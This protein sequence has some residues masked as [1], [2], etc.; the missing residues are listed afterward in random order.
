MGSI[1]TG[2]GLISGIDTA[3][4]IDSLIT[5]ESQGKFNLQ[6][7]IATLQAQ[8]TAML[9]VN[10]RLLNFRGA[11]DSFRANSIF[12][13]ALA[14]SSNEDVMTAVA[15]NGTAPGS[16]SFIVN[17]LV[18][19]SQKLSRGFA[20]RDA[21]P[22]GLSSMSFEFGQGHLAPTTALEVL[23]GGSGVSRGRISITDRT[24]ASA[25]VDLTDVTSLAEVIDRINSTTGIDVAARAEGDGLVITDNTAGGGTLSVANVGGFTTATE[26]G[27]NTD[28]GGAGDADALANG[29]IVGAGINTIGGNTPL[30]ALNDGNGVLIIDNVDDL[31]V[32]SK[33]GMDI[34]V[35]LG[36][37]NSPIDDDTL[38]ADL[39]NGAGIT[40]NSDPDEPDILISAKSNDPAFDYEID[41]TGVTTVGEL[42]G[43][44]ETA[45]AGIVTMTV[46]DGKRFVLEDHTGGGGVFQVMGAGTNDTDTAEDLGILEEAGV[47]TTTITG[48][49]IDNLA[50]KDRAQTVQDVLDRINDH[51]DNLDA[52]LA[53]GRRVTASIA[54][55]GVSLMITDNTGGGAG[56][57]IREAATNTQ[58][59]H[60][61][62]LFVSSTTGTV[63]DGDRV[64]AALDSVMVANLNGGTG[65]NVIGTVPL[66]GAT[67]L[68]DLFGGAGL[69]T[70]GNAASPDISITDRDGFTYQIE[71]DGLTT[72]Q[73]LINAVSTATGG[74]VTLAINGQALEI[75]NFSTGGGDFIV[76]DLNGSGT[77]VAL[78]INGTLTNPQG[79]IIVG[80]DTQP[81][82]PVNGTS[83][84]LTDR[85]GNTV[86]VGGLDTFVSLSDLIAEINT[87]AI[88]AGV[89]ITAGLNATGNGV[90]F[91]DTSGGSGNLI[92]TGDAA[93]ALRADTGAAGVADT[94][95]SGSNLQLGYVSDST[96]LKD[97]NYGRGIGT[98]GLRIT[99]GFG[100]DVEINIGADAVTV[101]DVLTEINALASANGV[102]VQARINDHGDGII[103][104][105]TYDPADTPFLPIRVEAAGGTTARDLN[106]LGESATIDD[107]FIEG[108][109]E[110]T[111]D[112]A[113]TDTLDDVVEKLLD[114]RIP[115]S[116]T[117]LN[118]GSPAAPF[119][120]SLTSEI[121]G[122][123]GEMLVDTGG[124]DLGLTTLKRGTDAKI[125]FG[126]DTPEDAF[127]ITSDSNTIDDVIPGLTLDLLKA[128]P[129]AVVV[130]IKRDVDTVV[131]T[132]NG[133]ASAFNDVIG[134]IDDYD[135][136][137]TDSEERGVLLGNPTTSRIRNLM[138]TTFS[139]RVE[140]VDSQFQ[141]LSQIGFSVGSEGQLNFDEEKFREAYENDRIGVEQL[142]VALEAETQAVEQIAPG[143][144]VT[145]STENITVR[146]VAAIFDDLLDRLIDPIDGI[147]IREDQSFDSRIE[148]F[149]DRI[150]IIDQRLQ[151]RRE[152]LQREFT[153][154][155]VALSQLQGQSNALLSISS[156]GR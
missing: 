28:D 50:S 128:S 153:A 67:S 110:V 30:S 95:V 90:Q 116:A 70:N 97:L 54:P 141:F 99:D 65:L 45:T 19:N 57:Q 138:F 6:A 120:L 146:G 105:S 25:T 87:Q 44:I 61:L 3:A 125:F 96:L 40:L 71:A 8:R 34:F 41:L 17:N 76:A 104:E 80:T 126:S 7:R 9:D 15:A 148:Q 85:N 119:R 106:I 108:S 53:A 64:V 149:E 72:V 75:E 130:D 37:I 56:L 129:E 29:V 27:I 137:D 91:T 136:F 79:D 93:V 36:R 51:E 49:D 11:V 14:T 74:V 38:L 101:H 145:N 52:G 123:R 35:D 154:M 39:N 152:R 46:E 124:V 66:A 147:M 68:A 115:V 48:S 60:D 144:T 133:F 135:F 140:G 16:Y 111:V 23:N 122:A 83:I 26:L 92:V 4:L 113:A 112:F 69:T 33:D 42:R 107:A 142:F 31:H 156:I 127:L 155:E 98:G 20:T 86:T 2:I 58:A 151:A 10:A 1:T 109:Y 73:D 81:Q 118:T 32:R 94:R 47:L 103:I 43:R 88:G 13:A 131:E 22:L 59:V 150:A 21:S 82:G 100:N 84:D 139:Q 114:A 132:V 78:G 77:A 5:L 24:G 62:G 134:R 117:I 55:D 143:V 12:R 18:S 121:G 102:K 89:A 63:R